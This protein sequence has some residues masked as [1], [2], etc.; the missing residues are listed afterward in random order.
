MMLRRCKNVPEKVRTN[1]GR[2]I[3]RTRVE[4]GISQDCLSKHIGVTRTFLSLVEN[5]RKFPSYDTLGKIASVLHEDV[6]SILIKAN[7]NIYDED[8][9]LISL[10]SELIESQND[11]K[12]KK[13]IEFAKSLNLE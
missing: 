12:I 3:Q 1:L 13:L 8:F 10:L 9:Q 7:M 5:G 4:K 2:V 11:E 6:S